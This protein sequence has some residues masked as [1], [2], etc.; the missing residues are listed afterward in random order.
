MK[1]I[2]EEPIAEKIEFDYAETVVASL[3][4]TGGGKNPAQCQ[5]SN[6]GQ[7]CGQPGQNQG[8]KSIGNCTGNSQRKQ[9][10]NTNCR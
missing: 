10:H 8:N 5:G 4:G 3:T 6:P 7:G 9:P 1:R 2:Y